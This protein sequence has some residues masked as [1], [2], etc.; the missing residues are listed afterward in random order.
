MVDWFYFYT[1]GFAFEAF[2]HITNIIW[3][4]KLSST[5]QL[6]NTKELSAGD[7]LQNNRSL[8]FCFV[9][10]FLYYF[11]SANWQTA[12]AEVL[13]TDQWI[14]EMSLLLLLLVGCV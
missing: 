14:L 9:S 4:N 11:V 3:Q 12:G 10:F 6:A 1:L 5:R 13:K 2:S 7:V 8:M